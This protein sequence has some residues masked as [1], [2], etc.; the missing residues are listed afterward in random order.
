MSEDL[1]NPAEASQPSGFYRCAVPDELS[2]GELRIG[3]KKASA[4]VQETSI[5]GFTILVPAKSRRM[6][7]S[8]SKWILE[9]Q[10]AL[11]Q[12]TPSWYCETEDGRVQIGL[13][14]EKDLTKPERIRR[15]SNSWLSRF[16]DLEAGFTSPLF[17]GLLL[18]AFLVL[19]LPGVGDQLGTAPLIESGFKWLLTSVDELLDAVF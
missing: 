11:F 3:W 1:L 19:A 17:G 10:N 7:E 2:R 5:D 13:T 8:R 16:V 15:S 4:S 12:V 9:F 18:A 6:L 14:N